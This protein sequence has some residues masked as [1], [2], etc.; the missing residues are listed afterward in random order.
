[1]QNNL[2]NSVLGFKAILLHSVPEAEEFYKTNGFHFVEVNMKPLH[3]L[4]SEYKAMYLTLRKVHMNYD[5]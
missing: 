2:S 3:N 5:E 1:M 4:D